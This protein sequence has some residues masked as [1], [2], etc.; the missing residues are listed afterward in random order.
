M[1]S[2]AP[3]QL[4]WH[5]STSDGAGTVEK[6]VAPPDFDAYVEFVRASVRASAGLQKPP[7][8]A[9][10]SLNAL[11]AVYALYEAAESGKTQTLN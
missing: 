5:S 11:S 2:D 3:E 4:H 1:Q 7:I 9:A 6:F 8:T 10:E